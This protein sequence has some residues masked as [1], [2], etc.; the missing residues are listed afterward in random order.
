MTGSSSSST[1][2]RSSSSASSETSIIPFPKKTL[3]P[4]LTGNFA[5]IKRELPL[6][7][8]KVAYGKVPEEVCGGQYI[9]NGG[10]P[11]KDEDQ[12]RQAHWFDGDG[13]LTGVLFQSDGE[14]IRPHFINRYILTD[15]LL[16]T[17]QASRKPFLPSISTFA[18][19]LS[20]FGF[21]ILMGEIMRTFVLAML[22][23]LP[24]QSRPSV[25]RISAANT[26]IW[27]HDGQAFAGCESGPPI[28]VLLPGLE[29]AAWWTGEEE[30]E[31]GWSKGGM[32]PIKML[33]EF[34]TAHPRID[35][36]TDELLLYHMSFAA[37]YLR[38]SV[39]PT[40]KSIEAGAKPLMGAAVPGLN[41]PKLAHDFCATSKR[42]ILIDMPLVLDPRNLLQGKPMLSYEEN[43]PT[44][45][46]ILPRRSPEK[47]KWYE[48][49]GCC[50]YHAANAWDDEATSST[51]LV[52]C[53]LNSATLVY[54]AGNLDTPSHAK[55]TCGT[56]KCQLYYWQ[57][58]DAPEDNQAVPEKN[59]KAQVLREFA[60]SDVPVEFPTM[61]DSYSQQCNRFVYGA[62][63]TTGSFD[64]GLGSR[65]AKIDCLAKFDIQTL[66]AKG[67]KAMDAGQ[68]QKG[69][70]VDK[71]TVQDVLAAEQTEDDPI[72]L[73]ALPPHHYAQEATFVPR[74]NAKSEDDGFLLFFVFDESTGLD[75]DGDAL[76]NAISQLWILDAKTMKDVICKICLPQRVPYGLHGHFF[77]ATEIQNQRPV[78]TDQVRNWA[79]AQ[80][81]QTGIGLGGVKASSD[82][83][84]NLSSFTAFAY[85]AVANFRNSIEHFLG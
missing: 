29:T 67:K 16:S 61:N 12:D 39:V 79:L 64:A 57:F 33:K 81:A 21:F 62:S 9:R 44:R 75:Y 59:E 65:S 42:T 26:S 76:P 77:S 35:P 45:F 7:Q 8:C 49:E 53:R 58:A 30:T 24:F 63:M 34:T 41:K 11:F 72:R 13:M 18:S 73:F 22:S 5:P 20:F 52:A 4:Y 66:I 54:A 60:L 25:K 28:R 71:R 36:E 80:T 17:S 68:L 19:Q 50:I 27:W 10:N 37:P 1:K 82:H 85:S 51:N 31:G 56:E 38:I 47:V 55:A 3:H 2:S 78:D 46:G 74:L 43:M 23:F 83:D 40:R 70:A 48:S 6:T 15:V 14:G 84:N 32:G 69:E